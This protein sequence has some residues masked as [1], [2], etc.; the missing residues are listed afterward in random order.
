MS[1]D[2]V[3]V[4]TPNF[5]RTDLEKIGLNP[6]ARQTL[7]TLPLNQDAVVAAIDETRDELNQVETGAF[8]VWQPTTD[9]LTATRVIADSD[10]VT[11]A[12]DG[13]EVTADL[14]DTGVAA[15]DYGEPT[16]LVVLAIDAKGRVTAASEVALESGNVTETTKLFFTDARARAAISDGS[17]IDYNSVNG[18]IAFDGTG[19]SGTFASPTSITVDDGLI[20]AI[21]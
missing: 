19:I 10:N 20:T 16:K 21:S 8:V 12:A 3:G 15:G 4:S 11:L 14:T 18:V 1:L 6:R 7:E 17:H 5:Q 9:K 13:S 2:P